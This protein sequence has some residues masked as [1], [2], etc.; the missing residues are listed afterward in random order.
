MF[1][2]FSVI[3][4]PGCASFFVLV[5]RFG[6]DS[7]VRCLGVVCSLSYMT[8]G[9]ASVFELAQCFGKDSAARFLS[10]IRFFFFWYSDD[11][12]K[13]CA[14]VTD[15]T[16]ICTSTTVDIFVVSKS[17][18][19]APPVGTL[20]RQRTGSPGNMSSAWDLHAFVR[21]ESCKHASCSGRFKSAARRQTPRIHCL[22][23]FDLR[24]AVPRSERAC[25]TETPPRIVRARLNSARHTSRRPRD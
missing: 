21:Q 8:Q 6:D 14:G 15:F 13:S 19:R 23:P 17:F 4:A 24:C 3:C 11:F 25:V 20:E 2:F 5:R 1:F 12:L 22:T 10:V 9:R 18:R 7:A 16:E